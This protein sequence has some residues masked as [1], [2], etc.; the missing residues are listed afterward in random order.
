MLLDTYIQ[1]NL[2]AGIENIDLHLIFIFTM[3]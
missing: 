1:Y 3:S 2:G